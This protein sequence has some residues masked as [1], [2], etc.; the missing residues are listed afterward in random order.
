MKPEKMTLIINCQGLKKAIYKDY[1]QCADFANMQLFTVD[2]LR[3][4]QYRLLPEY[5]KSVNKQ[6]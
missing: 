1:D 6:G 3:R 4:L 2:Q 5:N